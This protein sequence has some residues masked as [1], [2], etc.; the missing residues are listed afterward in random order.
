M[1]FEDGVFAT[2]YDEAIEDKAASKKQG[3][4]V[5][6]DILYIRIQIPN[7]VD[8]VP[9]PA[10]D[11]DKAR[12]PK[13]WEA[14]RTGKEPAESGFPLEEWA[15]LSA[16][17]TAMLRALSIK[18]VEQL[19]ATPDSGIHRLGPAGHSL[20]KR[21]Q[22]FL[23]SQ[24]ENEKLLQRIKELERKL[25]KVETSTSEEPKRRPKRLKVSSG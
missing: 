16:T 1:G 24:G 5:F 12:F 9:R 20:K 21:A 15:G 23:D 25:E 2:F 3:Y 19:A 8:C 14:Y 11:K 22:K 17:E 4:P 18:T 6:N 10:N 7:S 13:S